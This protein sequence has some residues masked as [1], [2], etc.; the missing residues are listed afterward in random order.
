LSQRRPLLGAMSSPELGDDRLLS[1]EVLVKRRDVDA[2]ARGDP[3][4]RQFR[5]SVANQNVSRRLEQRLD[6]GARSLLSRRFS[7]E[8]LRLRIGCPWSGNAS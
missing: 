6:G 2:G 7:G 4:R 5:V 3:I 1:R 8:N